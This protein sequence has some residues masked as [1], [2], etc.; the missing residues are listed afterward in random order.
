MLE[1]GEQAQLL[2]QA[3]LDDVDRDTEAF[4]Q[5]MAAW[6]LPKKNDEQK[7]VRDQAIHTATRQATLVP[8]QVLQRCV[9]AAALARAAVESKAMS[10]R[11]AT[12]ASARSL[13][14]YGG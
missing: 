2:K 11:S 12:P 1:I 14:S 4:K 3:F 10:I 6:R 7:A 8:L 9:Q 5:V 13:I